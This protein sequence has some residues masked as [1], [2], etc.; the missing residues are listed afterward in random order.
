M[1]PLHS[2]GGISRG[3]SHGVDDREPN[4][5]RSLHPIDSAPRR[6]DFVNEI[7]AHSSA[8][9]FFKT[10]WGH[11]YPNHSASQISPS[12]VEGGQP[13]S[14]ASVNMGHLCCLKNMEDDN[15]ALD[16][17]VSGIRRRNLVGLLRYFSVM[18]DSSFG[19]LAILRVKLVG[20]ETCSSAVKHHL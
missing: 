2:S 5:S 17:Q 20:H 12:V 7:S 9:P 16:R 4:C 19:H 13:T 14:S 6:K 10:F 1:A 8:S 15:S 11:S 3:C 18:L